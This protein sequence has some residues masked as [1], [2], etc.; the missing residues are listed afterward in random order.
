M[1]KHVYPEVPPSSSSLQD[2]LMDKDKPVKFSTSD[3]NKHR[4]YDTFCRESNAPWYQV[5]CVTGS[6]SV[7]LLYFCVF[8][9]END[10]DELMGKTLWEKIP[11][12]RE[13]ILVQK[14][15]EGKERGAD[16]SDLVEE[17]RELHKK[18]K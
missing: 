3:A 11:Q 8:R 4:A 7:F 15:K 2:E 12:L 1:H 5:Y 13:Q 17:L 14:I 16:V 9:E 18:H 10:L 6:I